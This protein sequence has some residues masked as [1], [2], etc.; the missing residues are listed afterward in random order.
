[1]DDL[2][3]GCWSCVFAFWCNGACWWNVVGSD[4]FISVPSKVFNPVGA[5]VFFFFGDDFSG[6][7]SR[8][9][10]IFSWSLSIML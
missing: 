5:G 7:G 10:G 6:M 9:P 8:V 1:M 3:V 2:G 4:V